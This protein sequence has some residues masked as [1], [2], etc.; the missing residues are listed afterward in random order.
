MVVYILV[1]VILVLALVMAVLIDRRWQSVLVAVIG[2][3]L[4]AVTAGL[5]VAMVLRSVMPG[6]F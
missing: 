5:A 6:A 2:G 4:V 1:S 3:L